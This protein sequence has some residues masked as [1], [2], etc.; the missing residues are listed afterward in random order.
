MKEPYISKYIRTIPLENT[1]KDLSTG[2]IE[3]TVT[4]S[5]KFSDST[6]LTETSETSD[7]DDLPI[8]F[9]SCI[10]TRSLE[11]IDPDDR[12]FLV[13]DDSTRHTFTLENTDEDD[14]IAIFT[15]DHLRDA[16]ISEDLASDDKNI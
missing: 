5:I 2:N 16:S 11:S 6:R 12:F 3:D 7:E 13:S 9:D 15:Y 4:N 1:K 14:S 10:E 8:L